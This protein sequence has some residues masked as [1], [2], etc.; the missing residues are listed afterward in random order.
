M[1]ELLDDRGKEILSKTVGLFMKYGIKSMTMDDIARQLGI[2]KK[3]LYIYVS[4]KNDLVVKTMQS[5][6]QHE[7]DLVSCMTESETNAIDQL[8]EIS[9]GVAQKFGSI[10]PSINYDLQKYHPEAWKIFS[11]FHNVFIHGCIQENIKQG[12]KQG[13]YRDNLDPFLIAHFYSSQVPMCSDGELFPSDKY[14]FPQIHLEM[15]RYHI[16]GIA[17]EKGLEYLKAKVKKEKIQL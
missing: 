5:I 15:M 3:T 4:D 11:D 17:S 9:K 8:F 16:R 12:M 13:L 6:V 1:S 14:S 7:K 10:H 2:S